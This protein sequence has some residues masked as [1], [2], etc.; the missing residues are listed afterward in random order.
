M[1]QSVQTWIYTLDL[2]DIHYKQVILNSLVFVGFVLLLTLR[3]DPSKQRKWWIQAAGLR[4]PPP[5]IVSTV[6]IFGKKNKK[7]QNL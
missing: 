3:Y 2:Y 1:S 7:P 6:F 5:Y 4:P